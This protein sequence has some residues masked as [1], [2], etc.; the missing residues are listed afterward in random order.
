MDTV[1]KF[2]GREVRTDD[3]AFLR[4]LIKAS[5]KASR[6]ALSFKVCE[7]WSWAQPNGTPCDVLCR[8]LMLKLHRAGHLVLPPA[9]AD[10]ILP[11]VEVPHLASHLLGAIAR[12]LSADWERVYA[13]PIYFTET[14]VEPE[15]FRGTCY[16]AANWT[17]LGMTLGLGKDA[18]TKRPNRSLKQLLGYPLVKDFQRRLCAAA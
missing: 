18:T 12:R 1:L 9:Q 11:W 6:R 3:L 15:R 8:G 14:F 2:R 7:A 10:L 17:V 5:P 4:D 13:H 16:R